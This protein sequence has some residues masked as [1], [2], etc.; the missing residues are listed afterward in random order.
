MRPNLADNYIYLLFKYLQCLLI[1]FIYI[2]NYKIDYFLLRFVYNE[3][4]YYDVYYH[5]CII[6]YI[7]YTFEFII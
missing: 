5:L 3:S 1:K 6:I 7:R 4:I 2:I